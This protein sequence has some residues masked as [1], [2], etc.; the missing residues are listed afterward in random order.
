MYGTTMRHR[1]VEKICEHAS[2]LIERNLTDLRFITPNALLY[3][4]RDGLNIN[5]EM[6]KQL[7]KNLKNAVKKKGRIFF[8]TFPSEVRPE[9]VT[10]ESITLI[11][12][13]TDNDNIIIGGQSGSQKVLDFCHRGH[14]VENI[15]RAVE[16]TVKAGLKANVDFI[17]G[18]PGET[19][20][21]QIKTIAV[22]KDLIAMGAR[23]HA[24]TFM[25]LW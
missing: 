10:N 12:E 6:L 8:G 4:S 13:Y 25:P 5:T 2:R 11:K 17:F 20:E 1:S 19:L 23:I 3:G 15:Y 18:L 22:I 14:M 9:H 24:H 21:D 7:L 16:V